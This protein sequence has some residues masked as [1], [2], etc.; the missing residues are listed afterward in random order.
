MGNNKSVTTKMQ[1]NHWR[2]QLPYGCGSTTRGAAPN[3]SR[4][5]LHSELLD[6]AIRHPA[7]TMVVEFVENTLNT[8]KMQLLP[9]NYV[10]MHCHINWHCHNELGFYL[11]P[12][13][14]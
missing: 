6:A 7:A 3:R 4:P 14:I 2:F 13:H 12:H 5:G 1:A 9:S 8:N 10:K 11:I